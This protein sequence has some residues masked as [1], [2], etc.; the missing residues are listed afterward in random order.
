M[1]KKPM[2][3]ADE[4]AA[5]MPEVQRIVRDACAELRAHY[6]RHCD[7]DAYLE[8]E[9]KDDDSPVTNADKAAHN[10]IVAALKKLTPNIPIIS[11]ENADQPDIPADGIFWTVDPLDGT[12]GFINKTGGFYVKIALMENFEPVLGVIGQ[13]VTGALFHS[14]RDGKAYAQDDQGRDREISTVKAT[15]NRPLRTA[16]NELHHNPDAYEA[17]KDYLRGKGLNIPEKKDALGKVSTVFNMAVATGEAEAYLDCGAQE[18]L[19]DGNGF[20]WDYAPDAL[21]LKNAGGVM[22]EIKT[23]KKPVFHKPTERMNAMVSLGDKELGKRLF[24]AL[25]NDCV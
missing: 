11:E 21:I 25:E 7:Q 6:K 22:I 16:F 17:A 20:S 14:V 18:A 5:R 10:I 19:E 24:P 23:G 12:K 8:I 15:E 1:G 9:I 4:L 3:S 13:P 2:I